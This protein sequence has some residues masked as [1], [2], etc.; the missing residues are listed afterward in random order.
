LFAYREANQTAE[1][2]QDSDARKSE[3]TVGI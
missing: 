2:F 1:F 3:A